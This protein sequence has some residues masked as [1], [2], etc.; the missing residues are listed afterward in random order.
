[1][2]P[3]ILCLLF[4]VVAA[5]A[6]QD[7]L[8]AVRYKL[9][10][11][12]LTDS[13][14]DTATA[15][16]GQLVAE[17]GAKAID[18]VSVDANR[19]GE[20]LVKISVEL[21]DKKVRA[22]H[23][24][25]KLAEETGD[26]RADR[27]RE[28]GELDERIARLVEL[29]PA[30]LAMREALVDAVLTLTERVNVNDQADPEQ[31]EAVFAVLVA[32]FKL[33]ARNFHDLEERVAEL[34]ARLKDIRERLPTLEDDEL[35]AAEIS[36]AKINAELELL[37]V[38]VE[39]KRV[40]REKRIA[41]IA[42][43]WP[44]LP[45]R[46]K[47]AELRTIRDN[48]K[49]DVEW[50]ARALYAEMLGALSEPGTIADLLN[51]MKRAAKNQQDAEKQLGPLREKYR[52]AVEALTTSIMGSSNNMVPA[53]V[54]HNEQN[55]RM[56]LNET[57]ARAFGEERVL[58][59]ASKGI[60]LALTSADDK[61]HD[62]GLQDL[63][64]TLQ[65]ERDGLLR[66][67]YVAALGFVDDDS[68]REEL[69]DMAKSDK[70][71]EVRLAALDAL[72]LLEDEPT[73]ELCVTELM[74]DGDWRVRAAAISYLAEVQRK[75]SVPALISA[76]GME[77]G[78]LVDDAENSLFAL[79]G[80]R[81]NGDAQL[82]KDWWAKN[83]DTFVLGGPVASA[84][85]GPAVAEGDITDWKDAPGHVSFYGIKTRSNRI[86]F[87][88]DRSG[89]MSEPMK[90]GVTGDATTRKIDAA[91]GQLKS[92]IAGLSDGERFNVITYAADIGRWQKRMVEM[93]DKAQDKVN[94]YIDN[95]IAAMGGTNIHDALM[96]SFRL[97]GIGAVDKDYD[98]SVDTIFFLS[99]GMPTQG[100]V[101]EPAEI[102]RRVREWNRLARVVIHT[103]GV[104]KDHDAAFLRRLAE[105]NGGVYVSR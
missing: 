6:Q 27:E 96:E 55:T 9:S 100:E 52:R 103:V 33:D 38:D 40:L 90:E 19:L 60:G 81:F 39:R 21:Q 98:A 88:L 5:D 7:Y 42:R 91:K 24:R 93:S 68:I 22:E 78:R 70:D 87:V 2:I 67:R 14:V 17:G 64:K 28:L 80:R 23:I 101:L 18:L 66:T 58:E 37:R 69:R 86:L 26:K 53:S 95:D 32:Y 62:R 83:K 43:L 89:S 50:Q 56:E 63:L 36:G 92:A 41:A 99:D 47:T 16:I 49:P 97:A 45:K 72:V 77:V 13:D 1:M 59:A 8:E 29:R 85:G 44:L 11:E 20:K 48:L 102:L 76:V 94:R 82:W 35:T 46:S 65:R 75:N 4:S 84:D 74:R 10:E 30:L 73:V 3:S 104:G 51:V 34:D 105:E 61:A 15:A 71:V 79:T 25:E 12:T 31:S 54:L 57:S